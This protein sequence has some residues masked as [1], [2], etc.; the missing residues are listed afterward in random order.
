LVYIN[1]LL[2]YFQ[3]SAFAHRDILYSYSRKESRPQLADNLL[4]SDDNI[5]KIVDFEIPEMFVKDDDALKS[6]A[7]SP[8]IYAA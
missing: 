6:T 2:I 4:L 5:R 3:S 7:G 8:V 1:D